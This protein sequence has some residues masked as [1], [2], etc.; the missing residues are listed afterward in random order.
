[1]WPIAEFTECPFTF[2]KYAPSTPGIHI[3]VLTVAYSCRFLARFRSFRGQI[4]VYLKQDTTRKYGTYSRMNIS[5]LTKWHNNILREG[6]LIFA[7]ALIFV[8][9]STNLIYDHISLLSSVV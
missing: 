3:R 4:A 8:I 1:M 5:A 7:I 2:V 6:K 9:I